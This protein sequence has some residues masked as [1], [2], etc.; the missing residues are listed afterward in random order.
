[1][2]ENQIHLPIYVDFLDTLCISDKLNT[3]ILKIVINIE[4]LR[5][6]E[7]IHVVFDMS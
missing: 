5:T 6:L 1:M 3:N 7:Y 4:V 2:Y